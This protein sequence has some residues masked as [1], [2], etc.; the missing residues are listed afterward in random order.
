MN[1]V[2]SVQPYQV[3]IKLCKGMI[4]K[5]RITVNITL[6]SEIPSEVNSSTFDYCNLMDCDWQRFPISKTRIKTEFHAPSSI[7]EEEEEETMNDRGFLNQAL[8]M[9]KPAA[10]TFLLN[11]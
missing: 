11:E 4:T 9:Q 2:E 10:K 3:I 5:V 8:D 6:L 1:E 7:E